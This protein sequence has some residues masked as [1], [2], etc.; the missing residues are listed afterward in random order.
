[1]SFGPSDDELLE[2]LDRLVEQQGIV[3]AGERLG[4]NYSTAAKCHE[5]CHVRP[6][7]REVLQKHMREQG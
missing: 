4:V 3:E 1:L 2:V 7:V 6:R 5:F